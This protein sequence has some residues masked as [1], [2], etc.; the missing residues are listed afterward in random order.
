M[1][2]LRY[3]HMD[4]TPSSRVDNHGALVD[5]GA[6]GGICGHDVRLISKSP[7][8]VTA[9]G[10]DH[11]E[12]LNVPLVAAGGAV[13]MSSGDAIA[14]MHQHAHLTQ[15]RTIHSCGQ[16]EHNGLHACDK[17]VIVGGKQ[18]IQTQD[19]HY[20]PLCIR[21]GP[22]HMAIRPFTDLEWET[23]PHIELTEAA[24][25]THNL[26]SPTSI[27]HE[28]PTTLVSVNGGIIVYCPNMHVQ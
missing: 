21:D 23:L 13:T 18:R 2:R 19:G 5:R 28:H 7:W 17:S 3:Q 22:P 4:R 12:I 25:G 20:K 24:D 8:T 16:M 9:R 1:R 15:E 14:I 10:L 11:Q 26:W 6:N 27:D